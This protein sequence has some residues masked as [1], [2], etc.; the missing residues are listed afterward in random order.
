[1]SEKLNITLEKLSDLGDAYLKDAE[2]LGL[3]EPVLSNPDEEVKNSA[4][5][6]DSSSEMDIEE[7]ILDYAKETAE[8]LN[9]PKDRPGVNY[10]RII[11]ARKVYLAKLCRK[12]ELSK[13]QTDYVFSLAGFNNGNNRSYVYAEELIKRG[14]SDASDPGDGEKQAVYEKLKVQAEKSA[15]DFAEYIK[16]LKDEQL[17]DEE[18]QAYEDKLNEGIKRI[19]SEVTSSSLSEEQKKELLEIAQ[20]DLR[21]SIKTKYDEKNEK[22]T[23]D[24]FTKLLSLAD[25]VKSLKGGQ[26]YHELAQGF[27]EKLQQFVAKGSL[28]DEQLAE[29]SSRSGLKMY[30]GDRADNRQDKHSMSAEK[31][32]V[33]LIKEVLAENNPSLKKLQDAIKNLEKVKDKITSEEYQ[34]LSDGIMGM[35]AK[36]NLPP[37]QLVNY[38]LVAEKIKSFANFVKRK[39]ALMFASIILISGVAF[40]QDDE[41]IEDFA[42][43]TSVTFNIDNLSINDITEQTSVNN[44]FGNVDPTINDISNGFEQYRPGDKIEQNW[45]KLKE[46]LQNLEQKQHLHNFEVENLKSPEEAYDKLLEALYDNPHLLASLAYGGVGNLEFKD[47]D[48]KVIEKGNSEESAK[49]IKNLVDNPQYRASVYDQVVQYLSTVKT[50][51]FIHLNN[52]DYQTIYKAV[53]KTTGKTIIATDM[54][55]DNIEGRALFLKMED[56]SVLRLRLGCGQLV[57]ELETLKKETVLIVEID[58]EEEGGDGGGGGGGDETPGGETPGGE[59]PGGKTPG[60]KT[61]GGGTTLLDHKDFNKLPDNNPAVI[62]DGKASGENLMEAGELKPEQRSDKETVQQQINEQKAGEKQVEKVT[63][64]QAE[65]NIQAAQEV[66]NQ[67]LTEQLNNDQTEQQNVI[68]SENQQAETAAQ[69]SYEQVVA[70]AGSAE[71]GIN[72]LQDLIEKDVDAKDIRIIVNNNGDVIGFEKTNDGMTTMP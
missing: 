64:Q 69:Q 36:F 45:E 58:L 15:S 13:E 35:V 6:S 7:Y 27:T 10:G 1:M 21:E 17:T 63:Q 32:L 12:S 60:G 41:K 53:E 33:D 9:R 56:G 50:K 26:G 62:S 29:L 25:Q 72:S 31:Y 70:E 16:I 48:G 24:E 61:P 23:E 37:A 59:T 5:A 49:L 66:I 57:F 30:Y 14:E 2:M 22:I 46:I 52:G 38:P 51:E 42:S 40:A 68:T 71:A 4:E 67:Q 43:K 47:A 18:K 3:I 11:N 55:G 39:T 8:I 54:R 19:M 44:S 28:S 65:K 34:E 20:I